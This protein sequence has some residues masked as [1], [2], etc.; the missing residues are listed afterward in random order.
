MTNSSYTFPAY[1]T[2]RVRLII[3]DALVDDTEGPSRAH[4]LLSTHPLTCVR[5][6]CVCGAVQALFKL[7]VLS[8][9]DAVRVGGLASAVLGARSP[10]IEW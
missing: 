9:L 2:F 3:Y 7:G 5:P 4:S 6:V 1:V 8:R 10:I